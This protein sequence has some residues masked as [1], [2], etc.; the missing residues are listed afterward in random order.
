MARQLFAPPPTSLTR[1]RIETLATVY[2]AGPLA[3][4][5]YRGFPSATFGPTGE[6]LDDIIKAAELVRHI[7]GIT[8]ADIS[9]VL[10]CSAERATALLK[11]W[12]TWNLIERLAEQLMAK[13]SLT[14]KEVAEIVSMRPQVGPE[15]Y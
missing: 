6:L 14:G 8:P 2:L 3:V 5:I 10:Q 1:V 15:T 11:D 7:P 4:A 9:E 13:G 12:A